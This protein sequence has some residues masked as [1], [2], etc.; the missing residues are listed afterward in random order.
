MNNQRVD[1]SRVGYIN[2]GL[3]IDRGTWR[4][5]KIPPLR[6]FLKRESRTGR[7]FLC[8]QV[9]W[10]WLWLVAAQRNKIKTGQDRTSISHINQVNL[11][12]PSLLHLN[13]VP[14]PAIYRPELSVRNISC[15]F[16]PASS[17]LSIYYFDNAPF[18]KPLISHS[19]Q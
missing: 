3:R 1:C 2:S 6:A 16:H 10:L 8:L 5:N 18:N 4:G 17:L 14:E 19:P 15:I 7:S 11:C 9:A 12:T 13:S